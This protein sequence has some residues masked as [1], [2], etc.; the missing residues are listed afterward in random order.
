MQ[1]YRLAGR[2]SYL[3]L[4]QERSGGWLHGHTDVLTAQLHL[5]TVAAAVKCDSTTQLSH[6]CVQAHTSR[7]VSQARSTLFP[8]KQNPPPP[9]KNGKTRQLTFNMLLNSF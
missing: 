4:E 8:L 2:S 6:N 3:L 9:K 5:I 7:T 1:I